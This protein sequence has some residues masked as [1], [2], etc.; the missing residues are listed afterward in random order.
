[1]LKVKIE[2]SVSVGE[3]NK[4]VKVGCLNEEELEEFIE[5]VKVNG[6]GI[7]EMVFGSRG[8][9][10]EFIKNDEYKSVEEVVESFEDVDME[11][12]EEFYCDDVNLYDLDFVLCV[13]YL[14]ESSSVFV[15]VEV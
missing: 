11:V 2:K 7:Y 1:M 6:G 9:V 4:L 12:V 13:S 14:E 5:Y 10:E 15:N 8:Y 3:L